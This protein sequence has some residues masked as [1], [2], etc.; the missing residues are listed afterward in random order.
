M[1]T[2][3][4]YKIA[5]AAAPP[6]VPVV[7][8]PTTG[9]D[10]IDVTGGAPGGLDFNDITVS[11]GGFK[12]FTTWKLLAGILMYAGYVIGF[13]AFLASIVVW[14]FGSKWFGRHTVDKAKIDLLLAAFGGVVLGSAGA[15]WTWLITR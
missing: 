1:I 7:P 5:A 8:T 15:V 9:G 13:L 12:F 10:T 2:E 11:D 3:Y 6:V 4:F 14:C